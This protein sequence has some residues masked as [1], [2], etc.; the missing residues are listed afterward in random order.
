MGGIVL[1]VTVG[2]IILIVGYCC[3]KSHFAY[4]K[5]I[6]SVSCYLCINLIDCNQ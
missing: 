5:D 4:P 6:D 2:G 3:Y 1:L